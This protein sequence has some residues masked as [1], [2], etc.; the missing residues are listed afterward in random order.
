MTDITL[1]KTET[2]LLLAAAEGE[3]GQLIFPDTTKP[4]TRERV[5]RR[6][7]REGLVA[8][9]EGDAGHQLTP[10][11]YRAVGLRPRRAKRPD[12]AAGADRTVPR[13]TKGTLILELLGRG[14]GASLSELVAATGWLPH[15]ARAALSRLRSSG[16][17]LAKSQ[18]EGGTT[19]YRIV[20]DEPVRR[21]RK[22][23]GEAAAQA[24]A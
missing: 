14:E 16:K 23:K 19:V 18:R 8:A 15:T 20:P 3:G 5:V 6:L 4:S 7:L 12:A 24:A 13:V 17:S 10:A 1:S 21:T 2:K 9:L 22:P 11:G